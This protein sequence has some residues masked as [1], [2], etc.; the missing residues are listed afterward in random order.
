MLIPTSQN[1]RFRAHFLRMIL[2]SPNVAF[3]ESESYCRKVTKIPRPSMKWPQSC[4]VSN[5]YL[6]RWNCSC[7]QSL[8]I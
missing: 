3:E 5:H 4:L 8:L 2:S 1:F 6:T 7:F